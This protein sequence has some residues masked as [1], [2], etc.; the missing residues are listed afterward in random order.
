M[1][2]PMSGRVTTI[3]RTNPS[4]STLPPEGSRSTSPDRERMSRVMFKLSEEAITEFQR[5]HKAETGQEIMREQAEEYAQRL[6][7]VVAFAAGID[8]FPS[9]LE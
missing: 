4:C 9:P 2:K 6:I 1:W 3:C 5:L 7:Q 8:P